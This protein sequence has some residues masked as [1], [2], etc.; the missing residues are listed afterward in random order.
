MVPSE[1]LV[2]ASAASVVPGG[3]SRGIPRISVIGSGVPPEG[4]YTVTEAA[5]L[6]RL[7]LLL[8]ILL[9]LQ[10]LLL[11]LLRLLLLLPCFCGFLCN[12]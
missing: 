3:A 9:L 11:L 2:R 6:E 5:W 7:L 10:L 12:S 1:P 4:A 8:L